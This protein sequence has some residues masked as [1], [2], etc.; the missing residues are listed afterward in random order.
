VNHEW[1]L[2]EIVAAV[3]LI[4]ALVA[5]AGKINRDL[6]VAHRDREPRP[7]VE[8]TRSTTLYLSEG[9]RRRAWLAT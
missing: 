7:V 8:T 2:G 9:A 4:E 5:E 6:L 1:L 3:G